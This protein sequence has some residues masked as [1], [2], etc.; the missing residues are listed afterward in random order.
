MKRLDY[1]G[2]TG[3]AD[4]NIMIQA[5]RFFPLLLSNGFTSATSSSSLASISTSYSLSTLSLPMYLSTRYFSTLESHLLAS[6]F[7]S[8][9]FFSPFLSLARIPEP[10]LPESLDLV[11]GSLLVIANVGR[12]MLDGIRSSSADATTIA[13]RTEA[14][15]L[16]AEVMERIGVEF[17]Y[18]LNA[19]ARGTA[20][21]G[22]GISDMGRMR[23]KEMREELEGIVEENDDGGVVGEIIGALLMIEMTNEGGQEMEMIVW[24]ELLRN[25]IKSGTDGPAVI[26]QELVSLTGPVIERLDGGKLEGLVQRFERARLWFLASAVIE[27]ILEIYSVSS[28][29]PSLSSA[30]MGRLSR[31]ELAGWE[32]RLKENE[33][34][35]IATSSKGTA[36]GVGSGW[37]YEDMVGGYVTITPGRIPASKSHL[38]VAPIRKHSLL[39][40][41]ASTTSAT[42]TPAR[43]ISTPSRHHYS[44]SRSEVGIPESLRGTLLPP[45][46]IERLSTSSHRHSPRSDILDT[47][48]FSCP[49]RMVEGGRRGGGLRRSMLSYST[50]PSLLSFSS[51]ASSTSTAATSN[52]DTPRTGLSINSDEGHIRR[53]LSDLSNMISSPSSDGMRIDLLSSPGVKTK[54]MLPRELVRPVVGVRKEL[55]RKIESDMTRNGKQKEVRLVKVVKRKKVMIVESESESEDELMM[56]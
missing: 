13:E 18:V 28:S 29:S 42:T 32:D 41:L 24:E 55:K 19:L 9:L 48:S 34:R 10:N 45:R 33:R 5:F 21:E 47:P 16:S 35:C 31:D 39:S 3:E 36:V 12:R 25:S 17:G 43:F 7:S 4:S 38:A 46:T 14:D 40:N 56:R 44:G 53:R 1:V 49:R 11:L 23:I 2:A 22:C 50:T 8:R 54:D 26:S 6:C 27:L 52:L 15:E 37:R 20:G 51:S 30:S